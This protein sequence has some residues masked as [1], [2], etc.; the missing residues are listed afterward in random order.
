[1]NETTKSH[2]VRLARGDFANYL[3]GYGIDIGAGPDPLRLPPGTGEVRAWDVG[4]GDA[5]YMEGV[6]DASYDFVYSSHALEHMR[7]VA[8]ALGNWCRILKPHGHLYVVVPDFTLY[9]QHRWPSRWN[10]DH[11]HSFSTWVTRDQ[12]RRDTHWDGM[13]LG[14]LLDSLGVGIKSYHLEDD[15]YDY[16][17]GPGYDQTAG[18][19]LAQICLI[20]KKQ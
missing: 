16:D 2:A 19:A 12:V 18:L 7:D 6:A 10:P 4:D 5:Q 3:H 14:M 1:M 13:A 17:I 9:E 20:G 8:T 15:G 11:K